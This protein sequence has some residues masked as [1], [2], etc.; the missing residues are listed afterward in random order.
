[1]ENNIIHRSQDD[2]GSQDK[3]LDEQEFLKRHRVKG[4]F[5]SVK[6]YLLF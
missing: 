6:V 2:T 5:D 4:R 1:M 3:D